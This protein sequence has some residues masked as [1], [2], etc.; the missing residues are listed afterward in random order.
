RDFNVRTV[1][2]PSAESG[3]T[4]PYLGLTRNTAFRCAYGSAGSE[5]TLAAGDNRTIR[6]AASAAPY[7]FLLVI[8]N[9]RRYGGSACFGGPAV[10]AID[11]AAAR[12]LVVH[13]FAHAMAGLADEY[14]LSAGDGPAYRGNI[15][16]WQPNVTISPERGKW[17]NLLSAPRGP[18]EG[19]AR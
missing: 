18:M 16:P 13:E 14:Y 10:V 5:R 7:D 17:R 4:E 6:E 3:V 8:A 2:V 1:F 9:S 11:S 19:A 15:E 12:Y